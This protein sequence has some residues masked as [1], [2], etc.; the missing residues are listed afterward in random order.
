MN[1]AEEMEALAFEVALERLESL[2]D[3]LE[4]GET[5]LAE[6]VTQYEQGSQLLKV[7]QS[8]LQEA[9]LRIEKLS[10]DATELKTEPLD[11]SE[12]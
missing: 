8:R 9:E 1:D 4:S 6:L 3:D 12:D 5:P 10:A 2:L 11:A 7:C